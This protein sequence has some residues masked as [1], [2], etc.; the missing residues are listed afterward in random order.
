MRGDPMKLTYLVIGTLFL[1]VSS[2]PLWLKAEVAEPPGTDVWS[3]TSHVPPEA[4]EAIRQGRFWRASRILREYLASVP[5]PTPETIL[6]AAQAE[7]GWGDWQRVQTLLSGRPWLDTVAGGYG[8]RLLGRSR[9]EL[10]AFE[11]GDEALRNYLRIASS[12]GEEDRG[13]V[14]IRRAEALSRAGDAAGSLAAYEAALQL[15][16]QIHDWI[17]LSAANVAAATGDTAAVAAWLDRTEPGLASD[18]GWRARVRARRAAGDHRGALAVAEAAAAR[19]ETAARRA[20]AWHTVGELRFALGDSSGARTAFRQAIEAAPGVQA[21]LNS[22]LALGQLPDMTPQD[23]LRIGRLYLR[24]GNLERGIAGL[25]AYLSAA[26]GTAAERAEVRLELGRAHFRAGRFQDA[27]RVMLALAEEAPNDRVG[28]EALYQAGRSQYRQGQAERGRATFLRTA[29]RFPRADAAA[30]ALFLVADLDHDAERL[31]S[32]REFYR[33]AIATGADVSEVGLAWMRLAGM[34]YAAGDYETALTLFEDY[35]ERFPTG[36]RAQQATYWAGLTYRQLGRAELAGQ[37]LREVRQIDPLSYYGGQATLVLGEPTWRL[38]LEPS[39]TRSEMIEQEVTGAMARLDLLRRLGWDEA[40]T[41]EV[42]RLR[43]H[44]GNRDGFL[45]A[46][47]EA[48]N[49]RGLTMTGISL[50]WEIYRRENVWNARLMRII[51]PFPFRD[52]IIAEAQERGVDPY[53]AAGL[54]RQES[55]FNATAVSPAGAIGL[56]QIMPA[57]GRA[58]ARDAGV[59]SFSPD[60]LRKPE[61][62]ISLGV[63]YMQEMLGRYGNRLTSVLAAYNAG[64]HRVT[65]WSQFPEYRDEELFAERIPFEET[66]NYVKVVQQN[67]RIYA[68][69]YADEAVHAGE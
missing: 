44:F 25:Q 68:L 31:T 46:L 19:L 41:F 13:I 1:A 3:D 23:R 50:G 29:E 58:L 62:N 56:M 51:Y 10:G 61:L 48:F 63:T 52:I 18:R 20:E 9:L 69:L 4:R 54:I 17:A 16:P 59:P 35:R 22:A 2:S 57:T 36:R 64:P 32:A 15:L 65:R 8:W 45:Y 26:A 67:A 47:A 53:L 12:A 33:R 6:L 5:D 66:R 14:M 30:R 60:L 7:A 34:A 40:A 39:P 27:E 28:A 42:E 43:R 38:H 11:D 24:H 55:M 49:E 21:A 37:R